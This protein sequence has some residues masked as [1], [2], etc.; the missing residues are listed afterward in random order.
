MYI[1]IV[2]N[3]C[4]LGTISSPML[5]V[6]MITKRRILEGM[7]DVRWIGTGLEMEGNVNGADEVARR[8]ELM[9]YA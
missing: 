9:G 3:G 2:V 7:K 5:P 8:N 6:T 4:G 1:N